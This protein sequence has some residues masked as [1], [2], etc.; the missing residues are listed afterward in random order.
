MK[1]TTRIAVGL[2]AA[3]ALGNAPFALAGDCG[4]GSYKEASKADYSNHEAASIV[5]T[6]VSAGSFKTLTAAL[7]AADLVGALSGD[8]PFTVFAPTDEAF[9]KL[10]AGTVETLLKPENRDKLISILTYHVIPTQLDAAHVLQANG[11]ATLNGGI[12]AFDVEKGSVKVDNASVVQTDI[13]CSNGVI[14]V[15]DTVLIPN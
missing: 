2:A 13:A 6:A 12:V 14:N 11:A 7:Q 9:A 10:P 4:S 1:N 5:E 3:L 8:G 15:I